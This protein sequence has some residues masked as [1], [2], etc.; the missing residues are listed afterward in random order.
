MTD[1]DQLHLLRHALEAHVRAGGAGSPTPECLDDD[2]VA[3]LAEGTLDAGARA[4][5]VAHLA[6]CSRCRSAVA[7][8]VRVL[9][10]RS[11]AREVQAVE[12]GG[13]RRLYPI[14]L[15]AAAAVLLVLAWPQPVDDGGTG[16]RA[17]TITAAAIPVGISPVGSVADA[18]FLRWTTVTGADRYR[19]TLFE[20]RGRVLY[21]TYLVDTVVALPDSIVLEPG[22][23]YLWK[24]EARTG[25]DRWSAS[26]LVEFQVAGGGVAPR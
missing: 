15:S 8:V 5:A 24:V 22:R 11:V 23:P 16:H 25:F 3:A 2:T 18:D 17:P 26:R 20:A 1:P 6:T 19:V 13:R 9:A 21:E 14:A 7:S 4:A 10:D 12:G